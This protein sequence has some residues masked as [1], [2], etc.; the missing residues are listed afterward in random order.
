MLLISILGFLIGL[1]ITLISLAAKDVYDFDTEYKKELQ[2]KA[3]SEA[4][5]HITGIGEVKIQNQTS[6]YSFANATIISLMMREANRGAH[7]DT[8]IIENSLNK[9]ELGEP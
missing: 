3:Q 8:K 4:P 9:E 6:I 2:Q 5:T 7:I 1:C